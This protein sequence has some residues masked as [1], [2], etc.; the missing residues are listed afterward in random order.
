MAKRNR[1]RIKA[2]M[3]LLIRGYEE[4]VNL[5]SAVR[6]LALRQKRMLGESSDLVRF[7]RLLADKED[8]LRIIGRIEEEMAPAR[9]L[10]TSLGPERYP[11]RWKLTV[12]LD[13]VWD[14]I[15]DIRA[16][17]RQSISL[18]ERVPEKS[19]VA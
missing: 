7:C 14:L 9:S 8:L 5:Y 10:V 13:Q 6:D 3:D 16:L 12:L 15:E 11:D 17:E 1:Q 19:S 2:A 18:L 4:E